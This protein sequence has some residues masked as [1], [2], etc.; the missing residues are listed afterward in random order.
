MA[1]AP[2]SLGPSLRAWSLAGVSHVLLEGS[3]SALHANLAARPSSLPGTPPASRAGG[4]SG[5]PAFPGAAS[6]ASPPIQDAKPPSPMSRPLGFASFAD[7]PKDPAAW[8]EPWAGWFAKISGAPVL[9]T[10]HELGADLVGVGRSPARSAFF[11]ELIAELRMPKGSSVFWPSAMPS[12]EDGS[13]RASPAVFAAGL[14]R[15]S[16]QIVAV[17]GERAMNDIGLSAHGGYFG[18][19]MVDGKL[20]VLLPELDDFLQGTAQR[21]SAVSLLRALFATIAVG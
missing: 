10:Y 20:L 8:P 1:V 11:K 4:P 17:F 2:V 21:A 6:P 12:L 7:L 14:S 13:L 3:V 19:T 9:W 16:P 15:L 18:Q 5:E